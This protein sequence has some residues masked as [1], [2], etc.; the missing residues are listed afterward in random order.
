MRVSG[1]LLLDVCR[2]GVYF[3]ELKIILERIIGFI[4]SLYFSQTGIFHTSS[5]EDIRPA[6]A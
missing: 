6:F 2:R 1:I 3:E 5:K 4:D